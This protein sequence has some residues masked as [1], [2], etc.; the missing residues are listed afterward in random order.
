MADGIKDFYCE[1]VLSGQTTVE[2]AF[3]RRIGS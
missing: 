2:V 1:E 3:I